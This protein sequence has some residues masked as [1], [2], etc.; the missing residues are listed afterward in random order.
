MST[1]THSMSIRGV[2]IAGDTLVAEL[3]HPLDDR[4]FGGLEHAGLGALADDGA[5]LVFRQAPPRRRPFTPKY[6]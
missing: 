6:A 5:D 4:L 1:S 3:E 2:M